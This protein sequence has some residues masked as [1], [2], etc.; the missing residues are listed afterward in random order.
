MLALAADGRVSVEHQ[1]RPL[2]EAGAAWNDEATGAVVR[3]V[4]VP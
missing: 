1:V 3:Q 4:L 2:A